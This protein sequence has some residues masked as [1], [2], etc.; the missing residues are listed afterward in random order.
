MPRPESI[1]TRLANLSRLVVPND[2]ALARR[3]H[4]E[5]RDDMERRVELWSKSK[6]PARHAEEAM[7]PTPIDPG[8]GWAV[9]QAKVQAMLGRG[10]ILCLTGIRGNGKT[11]IGVNAILSVTTQG[12]RALFTSAFS[13]VAALR[14]PFSFERPAEAMAARYAKPSLLVVDEIGQ[15][16]QDDG[17]ARRFFE[18]LNARYADAKDTILTCNLGDREIQESLGPSLVSRM[19]EG[20]GILRCDWPSFRGDV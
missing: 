4:Y 11:Q 6:V 20:G 3:K 5:A 7:R 13:M 2:E 16:D 15:M 19:N 10:F 1:A 17:A 8:H 14:G 12:R 9:A 18:V